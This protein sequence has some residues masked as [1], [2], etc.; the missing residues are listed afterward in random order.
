VTFTRTGSGFLIRLEPGDEL[1]RCLI[2][3][4]REQEVDAAEIMAAGTAGA[5]ELGGGGQG[6]GHRRSVFAEPMHA[7]TLTGT[8]T[9]VDGEPFPRVHGSFVRADDTVVS[10][11]VYE[12]VAGR[13]LEVALNVTALATPAESSARD[14]DDPAPR[15]RT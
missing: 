15:K 8:L 12:L 13:T 10:G 7:R 3:F 1:L 9:L 4:A 6:A 14:T 2:Q 5:V 11:D